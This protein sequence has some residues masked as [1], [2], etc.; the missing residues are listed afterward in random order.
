MQAT[1]SRKYHLKEITQPMKNCFFNGN[2][3]G[4][5]YLSTEVFIQA[6]IAIKVAY[7]S[8]RKRDLIEFMKH[9]YT[10]EKMKSNETQEI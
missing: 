3:Q 1:L 6:A 5:R 8:S 2:I 9:T 7:M 4:Y 10:F